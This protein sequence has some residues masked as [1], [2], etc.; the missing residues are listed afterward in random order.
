MRDLRQMSEKELI[1]SVCMC[2]GYFPAL[3]EAYFAELVRRKSGNAPEHSNVRTAI[4]LP[5]VR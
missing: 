5:W 2:G 4:P 3:T 1:T